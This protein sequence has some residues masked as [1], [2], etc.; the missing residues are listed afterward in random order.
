[1]STRAEAVE[2][3]AGRERFCAR[4]PVLHFFSICCDVVNVLSVLAS[5]ISFIP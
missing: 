5:L 3:L 2:K 4:H 1:M